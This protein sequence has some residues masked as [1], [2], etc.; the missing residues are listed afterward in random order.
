MKLFV[1]IPA[2]CL[3]LPTVAQNYPVRPL[4]MMVLAAAAGVTDIAAR[5]LAPHLSE[6][7]GQSVVIDNRAGAGGIIVA[8]AAPDGYTLI[9]VFDSFVSNP[10]VFKTAPY[11]TLKDFA[12]ILLLIR[13]NNIT[14]E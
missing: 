2:L 7:L 1:A 13:D 3:A 9:T 6:A 5:V 8:K 12:P 14:A 11:D 10:F 4:R